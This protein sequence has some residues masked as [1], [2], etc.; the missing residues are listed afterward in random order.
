MNPTSTDFAIRPLIQPDR[1][2]YYRLIALWVVCEAFLG[3]IIHGLRLPVSGLLVGSCSVICI[4][5][6][7]WYNPEKGAILKATIVVAVFK[8]MLSPQ[9]PFPAYIAVFFQGLMG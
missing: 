3:G 8:L 6:I 4:C 5:L 7:A 2:A 1:Q 9:S